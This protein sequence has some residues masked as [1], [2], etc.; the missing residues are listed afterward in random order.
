MKVSYREITESVPYFDG[1]NIPLS[2][3]TR[4]CRR[5]KEIIPPDS[6]RDLTKLLINKL[7]HRAYYA[8]EDEPCESIADLIDLLTGAFESPKTIDQY[9]G[10]LSII[11]LKPQEHVLDYISRVKELR[12]AII[13]LERREKRY[14]DPYFMS[15]VDD[16]TTRS[17]IDGLPFE[18]RIQMRTDEKMSHTSAFATAK[19]ISKR[20]ELDKKRESDSR[21]DIQHRTD[22]DRSSRQSAPPADQNRSH[23]YRR[24]SSARQ[25]DLRQVRFSPSN[26]REPNT[27]GSYQRQ[28]QNTREPYQN[29]RNE[30]QPPPIK[31]CNYCKKTGHDISEC[32]RR[33]YN[34][35]QRATSQR[36]SPNPSGNGKT[37]PG[38][39]ANPTRN[40]KTTRPI[41][42]ISSKEIENE[43]KT[44]QTLE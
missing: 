16:L 42:S 37:S 10:K 24:E 35:N 26:A 41:N 1:Y 15:Q 28:Y 22:Y 13:D 12:T 19:A 40:Q 20:K 7:G 38:Y 21:R 39:D 23:D 14:L 34:N 8:V 27:R 5:A 2:R 43:T 11:F 36:N 29:T 31:T 3:F 33:E 9:R 25:P 44:L 17:F 18:Y 30:A 32:R 6:E 4:A